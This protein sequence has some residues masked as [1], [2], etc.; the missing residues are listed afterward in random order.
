[1]IRPHL[2]SPLYAGRE[3]APAESPDSALRR[4]EFTFKAVTAGSRPEGEGQGPRSPRTGSALV[5]PEPQAFR[6]PRSN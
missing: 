2:L 1:M 4:H 3:L 5:P 6:L